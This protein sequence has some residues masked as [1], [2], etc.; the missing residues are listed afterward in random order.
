MGAR[1]LPTRARGALQLAVALVLLVGWPRPGAAVEEGWPSWY[2]VPRVGTAVLTDTHL[3]PGIGASRTQQNTGVSIG[4]DLSPRVGLEL[5]GD[6]FET[7]VKLGVH[8]VGEYGVFTLVPQLRVRF[9][10]ERTRLTPYVV[11]G[12][13]VSFAEFNDRKE[14]GIGL[15]VRAGDTAVVGTVGGG[16][17]YAVAPDVALGVDVRYL[18]ARGHDIKIADAGGKA[19]LDALLVS[20]ALRLLLEPD[21]FAR[22]ADSTAGDPTRFLY[23]ALRA[24]GATATRSRIARGVEAQPEHA[25]IAG[26]LNL[27]F[28]VAVGADLTRH[29]GVEV[30]ADGHEYVL[31]VPGSGSAGEYAIYTVVP[32]VR[33]RYP[34]LDDRL[35]PYALAG[36]GVSYAEFNDRK[37]HGFESRL[38]GTDYG[39]VATVGAGVEWFVSRA[40]ALGLETK[41]QHFL[42]GHQLRLAGEAR[43]SRPHALLTTAGFRVY[44]GSRPW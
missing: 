39:A 26:R 8:N 44:F 11:A 37:P 23:V 32:Q 3:A 6:A 22:S 41:Y 28:G 17:E 30:A 36:L 13:G 18:T 33:A 14:R 35:V 12:V 21:G 20:G 29:L 38:R 27:L 7:N 42:A 19:D 25:A 43:D 9:P 1:P 5:A 31:D 10:I 40:I 34:L 2:V 16:L 4:I 15:H 24:G